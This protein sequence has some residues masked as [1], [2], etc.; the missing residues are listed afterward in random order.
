MDIKINIC[1]PTYNRGHLLPNLYKS[2]INQTFKSFEWLIIDDGSNDNTKKIVE[3]FQKENKIKIKYIYK[4]NGGKHTALNIGIKEANSELFFIVDSDDILTENSLELIW[5]TWIKINN[6]DE[7]A[8]IAGLRGYSESE[9]IGDTF[10]GKYLDATYIDL[11]FSKG[12]NGDKAEVYRTDIMKKYVFPEFKGE[13]FLTEAVVWNRIANDNLKLRWINEIIYIT[14]YLEGGLTDNYSKLMVNNWN[15]TNL[16]Y[17]EI[18]ESKKINKQKRLKII[19]DEYCY[20]LSIKGLSIKLIKELT[21]NF[22]EIVY[23][24]LVCF[25]KTIKKQIFRR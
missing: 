1:T 25:L 16:Y 21:Y 3:N 24:Y 19:T 20:Y 9:I 13:R 18:L 22:F 15:G 8:G 2:L 7:F 5:E 14:E 6:K 17:K 12:I 10:E 4:N 23:I 11:R